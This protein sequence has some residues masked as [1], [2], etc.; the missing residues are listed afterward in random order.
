[1]S[2]MAAT[3]TFIGFSLIAATMLAKGFSI[4]LLKSLSRLSNTMLCPSSLEKQVTERISMTARQTRSHLKSRHIVI[5]PM[6]PVVLM[7]VFMP[8]S[9]FIMNLK[10]SRNSSRTTA[11]KEEVG[12]WARRAFMLSI[13][14]T[15]P[16][17]LTK[18]SNHTFVGW[19]RA[20][21]RELTTSWPGTFIVPLVS[22]STSIICL[23]LSLNIMSCCT[24]T[25]AS[26]FPCMPII[27]HF[28]SM[29]SFSTSFWM[30]AAGIMS[31]SRTLTYIFSITAASGMFSESALP[32]AAN[33]GRSG[34]EG[35]FV[36]STE[37]RGSLIVEETRGCFCCCCC[38]APDSSSASGSISG[39]STMGSNGPSCKE[40]TSST[41]SLLVLSGSE[42]LTTS[43]FSTPL[44]CFL[45]S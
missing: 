29:D 45:M 4:L 34:V 15:T 10:H 20:N 6:A 14:I 37:R 22:F 16:F 26:C 44:L 17:E 28:F 32:A 2:V 11:S 42:G 27:S 40:L 13:S 35:C 43:S 33:V 41:V 24:L 23:S 38:V 39:S 21:L 30:V 8:C 25:S 3:L 18:P 31:D 7:T 1:M 5:V 19:R 12:W 9:S 36:D